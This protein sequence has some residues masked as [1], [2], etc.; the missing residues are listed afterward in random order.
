LQTLR[1]HHRNLWSIHSKVLSELPRPLNRCAQAQALAYNLKQSVHEPCMNL[2]LPLMATCMSP[3]QGNAVIRRTSYSHREIP[4]VD[5]RCASNES[6]CSEGAGDPQHV[7]WWLKPLMTHLLK[8]DHRFLWSS[9]GQ[10]APSIT[11]CKHGRPSSRSLRFDHERP[12]SASHFSPHFLS[13]TFLT[14]TNHLARDDALPVGLGGAF[15]PRRSLQ[16]LLLLLYT[17]LR[18][19][20]HSTQPT[21]QDRAWHPVTPLS[22]EN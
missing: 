11:N 14:G 13:A 3:A 20:I 17:P 15:H 9:Q 12:H 5:D 21:P 18:H 19:L 8:L 7:V 2:N 4:I 10:G 16:S 6:T 1:T 22:S